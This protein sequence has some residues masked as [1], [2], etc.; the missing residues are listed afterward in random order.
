M[1]GN[2]TPLDLQKQ[3]SV[4]SPVAGKPIGTKSKFSLDKIIFPFSL[5]VL[6]MSLTFYGIKYLVDFSSSPTKTAASDPLK[7][8]AIVQPTQTIPQEPSV[9]TSSAAA[10]YTMIDQI[11]ID[12]PKL[13]QTAQPLYPDLT[14][15]Q[16]ITQVNKD[17]IEWAAMRKYYQ[18]DA[19][20]S[21]SLRAR[22]T[23]PLTSF[24]DMKADVDQLV[25]LYNQ[26][27]SPDRSPLVQLVEEFKNNAIL[28]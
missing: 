11:Q 5:A 17:L 13:L 21:A 14:P 12:S 1:A 28:K 10:V 20:L 2:F 23:V 9:T 3:L 18:K 25:I 26:D 27:T 22:T 19:T 7:V 15:D 8:A 4:A 24:P 6:L 16:L